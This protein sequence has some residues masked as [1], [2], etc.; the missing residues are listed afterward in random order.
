MTRRAITVI[1]LAVL[2]G[3]APTYAKGYQE[4]L[5]RGLA[6]QN[7][8]RW[9]EAA[10]SFHEAGLLGDR[11]KDRDE[12]R[13]LEAHAYERLGKPSDADALLARIVDEGGGRYQAIRAEF[14]RA[15]LVTEYEG[16]DKGDPLMLAAIQHHPTSGLARHAMRRLYAPIEEEKGADAAL[17][18]LRALEPVAKGNELEEEVA[19]EEGLV[20]FRA[21]R[22][23]E[24]HDVF[25]ATA[26]AHPYPHGSLTDDAYYQASLLA[27]QLGHVD[28]AIELLREMM[29]P[30]E[31]AYAGSSYERPRFPEAQLRVATLLRDAKHDREGAK[32]AF[33]A[34]CTE[35]S[36]TRF[37]DD[38]LWAEARLEVEDKEGD[39]ACESMHLLAKSRPESRYVACAHALCPAI[40]ENPSCREYI[41]RDLRGENPPPDEGDAPQKLEPAPMPQ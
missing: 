18:W 19:Y 25:V 17:A 39:R 23:Q 15:K 16:R 36:E 37:C 2:A 28:E 33:R 41:L 7:A 35:R 5:A 6:A 12:A 13:L 11:Y 9:D 31:A 27:E 38:A 3:C 20:L 26:R 21:G 14:E 40:A 10:R 29:K 30:A 34:V 22:Y 4:A 24:A 8:G 32:R 1:A